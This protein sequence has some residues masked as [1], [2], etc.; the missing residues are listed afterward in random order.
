M[1][2]L[3]DTWL[4]VVA[5]VRPAGFRIGQHV[6]WANGAA[7][8]LAFGLQPE[9]DGA[10][11]VCVLHPSCPEAHAVL[12][13]PAHRSAEPFA[14]GTAERDIR[15]MTLAW[16]PAGSPTALLTATQ[17]GLVY[18]WTMAPPEAEADAP[19]CIHEWHGIRAADAGAPLAGAT[20]LTP[21]SSWRWPPR[22]DSEGGPHSLETLFIPPPIA[23]SGV[24][25]GCGGRLHWLRP[26]ML[27]FATVTTAGQLQVAWRGLGGAGGASCWR[28][29]PPLQLPAPAGTAAM[30]PV[31]TADAAATA[32]GLLALLV[33]DSAAS[34]DAGDLQQQ[35]HVVDIAGDPTAVPP[36]SSTAAQLGSIGSTALD[37]GIGWR[38]LQAAFLP[39][40]AGSAVQATVAA[41]DESV[42][43]V[44]WTSGTRGAWSRSQV[45]L[46]GAAR[47]SAALP[48]H[49]ATQAVAAGR[50]AMAI[51]PAGG[52]SDVQLLLPK[53]ADGEDLVLQ[54]RAKLP[55]S[56]T[57]AA[58]SPTGACLATLHRPDDVGGQGFLRVSQLA[59]LLPAVLQQQ[60]PAPSG[61]AARAAEAQ[62]HAY[63][64]AWAIVTGGGSWCAE[65]AVRRDV[66]V[67][68]RRLRR[69]IFS[70]LDA[71]LH[72]NAYS[73][74]TFYGSLLDRVKLRVLEG[75]RDAGGVRL[76]GE[77]RARLWCEAYSCAVNALLP[78]ADAQA[79]T[80]KAL[81]G[82]AVPFSAPLAAAATPWIQ[83]GNK[84]ASFVLQTS[85][86][87][88]Q[89]HLQSGGG[90]RAAAHQS[91]A[92]SL[93][94]ARL[95]ADIAFG[96]RLLQAHSRALAIAVLMAR[97]ASPQTPPQK[98]PLAGHTMAA[99]S[100]LK[101]LLTCLMK[102]LASLQPL[103]V[104]GAMTP[105]A[106]AAAASFQGEES[107]HY[108]RTAGR[109]DPETLRP[110]LAPDLACFKGLGEASAEQLQASAV[111]LGLLPPPGAGAPPAA[112][113]AA[114]QAVLALP[115][116]PPL[117][118]QLFQLDQSALAASGGA[119]SQ[120]SGTS[121]AAA[122]SQPAA[123]VA[124]KAE[125]SILGSWQADAWAAAGA[126]G[127]TSDMARKRWRADADAALGLSSPAADW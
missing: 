36:G 78:N 114:A 45:Q 37:L 111:A 88:A 13:V 16:S 96:K 106:E 50:L 109:L 32:S 77:L 89:L 49:S 127:G 71:W 117:G 33:Y 41:A 52:V 21:P 81:Q 123:G 105:T 126:S 107:L 92:D 83:L 30:L 112:R 75:C 80:K 3:A 118:R 95:L 57:A 56:C 94:G 43:A 120:S 61:D 90:D 29:S 6:A 68:G 7:S 102:E 91:E 87:W 35:L 119:M 67:S 47:P 9:G 1:P 25:G 31:A 66:A 121:G 11:P 98:D 104:V 115:A 55:N 20:W 58:V 62:Q 113:A 8:L 72:A 125:V 63:R 124:I 54:G 18:V 122:A 74:R 28:V 69:Q 108:A 42:F 22:P 60:T 64:L 85:R 46:A 70:H 14:G 24:A 2:A 4:P 86:R 103:E 5:D 59:H 44:R 10:V 38:V 101:A 82:E 97:L 76:R 48:P 19:L 34:G 17:Q 100:G 110:L 73:S 99:N 40:S 12:H 79:V 65:A 27:A 93:L 84:L 51:L 23:G 53:A 15:L 26:G 116:L 39:V